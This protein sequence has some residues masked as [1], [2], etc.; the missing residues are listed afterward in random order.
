MEIQI[1]AQTLLNV[2]KTGVA[3]TVQNIV[4]NIA[5]KN[6]GFTCVL[7]YFSL[8]HNPDSNHFIDKLRSFGCK[9]NECRWFN[10]SAYKLIYSFFP[11]PYRLFFGRNADVTLFM[12]Y[13]VP[14]GASGKVITMV[15]DM[16]YK[17]YPETMNRK[18][19]Y[20]LD[21][22][23]ERSCR[24][25]DI[26]LTISQFSKN[27][28]IKY[29]H[30][31]SEKIVVVPCGV[32]FSKF[33]PDLGAGD[34]ADAKSKYGITGEYLHYLGT[35]EPRKNIERL[36]EAYA[37]LKERLGTVPRLVIAGKKGWLYDSIFQKVN[38]LK[39][40]N[41]VI[42]TGYVDENDVPGLMKG[43]TAFIFPSLYEGFGLPPLEAM[44]CGTPV[45]V[46]NAA[47]LPEVVGDAALL[48]DPFSVVS[49]SN[50]MERLLVNRELRAELS[51]KGLKQ[52]SKYTWER[53]ADIIIKVC[54]QLA[55]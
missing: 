26:I 21:L 9:P 53:S 20:M 17:A 35:L 15:Y 16:V 47:S 8:L 13:H 36:I 25:A 18:T 22:N 33:R 52:A 32:D 42:F 14:P 23:M 41:D 34:I 29:L 19:R 51:D 38:F 1:D 31:P 4:T 12:N 30:V 27:E 3:L 2:D 6:T 11:L 46:S 24:R 44:A 45:I 28:I 5:T 37:L 40:D 48:V 49:I 55:G 39:L 10:A 54:E 43:A 7:N 50:A